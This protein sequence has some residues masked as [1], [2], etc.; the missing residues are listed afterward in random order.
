[1]LKSW[2]MLAGYNIFNIKCGLSAFREFLPKKN[3]RQVGTWRYT[4]SFQFDPGLRDQRYIGS[5]I[6]MKLIKNVIQRSWY[7]IE[8]WKWNKL[9]RMSGL[10][11]YRF[12]FVHLFVN[13]ILVLQKLWERK[14]LFA[15]L[16]GWRRLCI[17]TNSSCTLCFRHFEIKNVKINYYATI[18]LFKLR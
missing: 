5:L 11:F 8:L 13:F 17:R 10:H 18:M 6:C 9:F 2:D 1:M 15:Y 7:A 14:L 3:L 12:L 4:E 16:S